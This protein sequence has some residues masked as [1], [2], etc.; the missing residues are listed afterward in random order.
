MLL[1]RSAQLRAEQCMGAESNIL[2]AVRVRPPLKREVE[3]GR[4]VRT[5]LAVTDAAQVFINKSLQPILVAAD[6]APRDSSDGASLRRFRYSKAFNMD[7]TQGQ[8]YDGTVRSCVASVLEGVNATV[9]A[10]G[11][12]GSGKTFTMGEHWEGELRGMAPR[13][14]EEVLAR[15]SGA[16]G[17]S[18]SLTCV[19]VYDEK[20]RDLLADRGAALRVRGG[21]AESDTARLFRPRER[22]AGG[23]AAG[24]RRGAQRPPPRIGNA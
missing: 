18:V 3:E 7:S 15:V 4:V 10:Y 20:C 13:A 5:A 17:D 21:G 12:T 16:Q 24:G 6:G 22:R 2:V 8:V 9:F 19:E 14:V 23:G 1:G 11:Q